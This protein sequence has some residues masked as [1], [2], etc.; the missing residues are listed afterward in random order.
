MGIFVQVDKAS[1]MLMYLQVWL[2]F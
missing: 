2:L 1:N